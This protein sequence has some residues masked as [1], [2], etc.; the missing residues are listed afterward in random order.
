MAANNCS[1]FNFRRVQGTNVLSHHALGLAIDI[2]PCQ[3][4]WVRDARV[5]PPA[6]RDYL[7]REHVRPG[8]IV[9]P[10]P[11]LAA[12][13]AYGWYWGGDFNGMRDYHH[14]SKLPR[15]A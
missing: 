6:A 9:R 3:N 4:P 2:N 10:G 8:M 7:D 13:A 15:A 1:A 5:D 14:F 11:V 12:F